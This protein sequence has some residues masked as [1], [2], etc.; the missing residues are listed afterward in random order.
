LREYQ[1]HGKAITGFVVMHAQDRVI[2]RRYQYRAC[3]FG[4][5]TITWTGQFYLF[6]SVDRQNGDGHILECCHDCSL[7][8]A[9]CMRCAAGRGVLA[10]AKVQ[11]VACRRG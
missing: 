8:L 5:K 2:A 3:A 6:E 10:E 1:V 7:C 4:V 9:P 11:Q